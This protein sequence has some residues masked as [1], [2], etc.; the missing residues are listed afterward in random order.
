MDSYIYQIL[1]LQSPPRF[2]SFSWSARLN[3]RAHLLLTVAAQV[4]E[5]P[6]DT[7]VS[8]MADSSRNHYDK[9]KRASYS[10][11]KNDVSR[12]P[13]FVEPEPI[14]VDPFQMYLQ[15][16][17]HEEDEFMD[18]CNQGMDTLLVFVSGPSLRVLN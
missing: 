3:S 15:K 6:H 16:A 2:N 18:D 8:S 17:G 1:A 4:L 12:L 10:V 7:R 11:E 14:V 13:G 9:N 5:L